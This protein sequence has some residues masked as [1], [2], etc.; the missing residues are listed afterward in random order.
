M[1]TPTRCQPPEP[2]GTLT[3][4]GAVTR[5]E[6]DRC[7]ST[8]N[9]VRSGSRVVSAT[10]SRDPRAQKAVCRCV[11]AAR[12]SPRRRRS[13]AGAPAPSA[14][15]AAGPGRRASIAPSRAMSAVAV[16][17]QAPARRTTPGRCRRRAPRGRRRS[18]RPAAEGALRCPAAS[19]RSS[20]ARAGARAARPSGARSSSSRP[21]ARAAPPG[22]SRGRRS[23]A[24]PTGGRPAAR[25]AA[26]GL[27]A[28]RRVGAVAR[29]RGGGVVDAHVQVRRARAPRAAS[30]DERAPS[31]G[32]R[33][34]N[35]R[36]RREREAGD[37]HLPLRHARVAQRREVV[38]ERTSRAA[39]SSRGRAGPARALRA[40]RATARPRRR[41]RSSTH[42]A[43]RCASSGVSQPRKTKLSS[44]WRGWRVDEVEPVRRVVR[45][46]PSE[47]PPAP[48]EPETATCPTRSPAPTAASVAERRAGEHAA[49]RGSGRAA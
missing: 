21:A 1:S 35:G 42:Q 46:L 11:G 20:A 48:I 17:D 7:P 37:R 29:V 47:R 45:D 4:V 15:R 33:R 25:A 39:G 2:R 9:V 6:V 30:G 44:P 14:A 27:R 24:A 19:R 8:E 12:S 34:A 31:A 49:G 32:G 38:P 43:R 40:P 5:T 28:K 26:P 16:L 3:V 23:R 10:R 41:A 22:R 18:G 13:A 36:Q